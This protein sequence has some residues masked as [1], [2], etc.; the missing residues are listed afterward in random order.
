MAETQINQSAGTIPANGMNLVQR[1]KGVILSPGMT[2]DN[3]VER[4]RLLLPLIITAVA[5]AAVYFARYPMYQEYMNNTIAG[6]LANAGMT[7]DAIQ[8]YIFLG[9]AATPLTTLFGWFLSAVIF[10]AVFK[11]FG[12]KGKFKQYMSIIGYAYII[13]VL[14]Y[15]IVL[16]ASFFTG[17]L[18]MNI[19]LTSIANL[20]PAEMSGSFL[21]GI[22]M[23][24]DI[25]SIWYYCVIAI[26]MAAL[27]GFRKRNTYILVA[28]IY[29][30]GLIVAG[31]G[32]AATNALTGG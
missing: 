29:V 32:A 31:F 21:Y 5:Q 12:A 25:F 15:I 3:L 2:M 1:I 27:S 23:G 4:P 26:G 8:N 19:T 20:L 11:I 24:I 13:Y 22:A 10:F 16:V 14:Y 6:T 18:Y 9:A 30:A 7:A 17:S 28:L